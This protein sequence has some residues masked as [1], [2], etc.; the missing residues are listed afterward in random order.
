MTCEEARVFCH[1]YHDGHQFYP[2][3]EEERS[4]YLNFFETIRN[5]R[6]KKRFMIYLKVTVVPATNSISATLGNIIILLNFAVRPW[7][8]LFPFIYCIYNMGVNKDGMKNDMIN[9]IFVNKYSVDGHTHTF[10]YL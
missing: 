7:T 6:G 10:I 8:N 1:Q 2:R 5:E 3:D 4:D 9:D